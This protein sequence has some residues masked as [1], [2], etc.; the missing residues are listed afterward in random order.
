LLLWRS[1]RRRLPWSG[2][3]STRQVEH[4]TRGSREARILLH[5][6]WLLQDDFCDDVCRRGHEAHLLHER[7]A[8]T[9]HLFVWKCL[10]RRQLNADD[11]R[12]RPRTHL[13]GGFLLQIKD[14]TR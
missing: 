8:G 12:V 10:E 5:N 4:N 14:N 1:R 6:A 2:C 9:K 13:I 11:Q 7:V 3:W